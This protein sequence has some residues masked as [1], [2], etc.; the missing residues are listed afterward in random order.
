MN[1]LN[2]QLSNIDLNQLRALHILLEEV[3]VGKAAARLAIT[4]AATS[5]TLRRLRDFFGD[6][7][8]VRAGQQMVLTA[9]GESLREPAAEF[10]RSAECIVSTNRDGFDARSWRG[11]FTLLTSDYVYLSLGE[12]L[13]ALLRVRVPGLNLAV[14]SVGSDDTQWLRRNEGLAITP[15]A[16][17]TDEVRFEPLFEDRMVVA[18][19]ADHPLANKRM[20]LTRYCSLAHILVALRGRPGSLVDNQL[21]QQGR[22]RR[23]ARIVPTHLL[24]A[25]LV[26]STDLVSA[27]PQRFVDAV[28]SRLN[29]V[30][31]PLPVEVKNVT[32]GTCWHRRHDGSQ[33]HLAMRALLTEA[34]SSVCPS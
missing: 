28:G 20:T 5:N 15:I 3:S 31:H 7:L 16:G 13:E 26:S 34:A 4:P 11:T 32:F 6:P 8:L 17:K 14:N 21:L 33:I 9:L 1:V 24:A 23:V 2:G 22:S 30:A 10:M 27:L 18:M 19:R 25:H 12:R 29:L